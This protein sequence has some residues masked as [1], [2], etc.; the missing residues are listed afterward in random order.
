MSKKF[1]AKS[2]VSLLASMLLVQAALA[3]NEESTADVSSN[4]RAENSLKV[5]VSGADVK[6]DAPKQMLGEVLVTATSETSD[7]QRNN[8]SYAGKTATA[9]GKVPLINRQIPNSVSVLTRKQ[10]DDQNMVTMGD[11]MQQ[12]TGVNVI[13][14]DTLNNQYFARGYG[15]G[16][17]YDGIPSYNGMTPSHQFDLVLYERIEVLRG[18][19]G[20]LRGSGEPGGVVN[21]IKKR[22]KDTFG[23]STLVSA[24]SWSNYR[25]EGDITGAL[26]ADK[27][28]RGRLIV[29]DE[30]RKYFYDHTHS[31]KWLASASLEYDF[32]PQTTVS[33]AFSAQDQDVKAPSSG[34]PAYA[35]LTNPNTGIYPLLN[36]S[37]S[38]FNVPD[39]G[40]T[41]YH[42]EETAVSAEHKFDNQWVTKAAV[43]H[44][45]QH[46][47]YKYAFTSTGVNPNTNLVSYRSFGGNYDYTRD[48]LDIYADGPFVLLGRTHNLLFG[49]NSEVYTSAG[50]SGNGPNYTNVVFGDVSTLIEPAIAYTAGSES[51]TYQQGLYSQL[52]LSVTDPLTAVLG[53]RS[54]TF[55][56]KTR[57]IAPS[58]QTAWANGA[59]ANDVVT[60]FA[61]VL[62]DLNK[63]VTLYSSYADIFVPQTQ[64]KADGS[65]LDPRVGHQYEVGS[66]G[67]FFDGDLLA[68]L[69][70]FNIRDKNRAFADP[71]YPTS[72]FY[73]NAGEIESKGWE[74]ET[75]GKPLARLDVTAGYTHLTTHYLADR[76]NQGLVYSIQTPVHQFK[77]W[78]NYRFSAEGALSGFNL[79]LGLLANS[80]VQSSRG[81][82]NQLMTGGYA[83]VNGNVGYQI[84]KKSSLSLQVNNLLDRKYYASVGTPNTYNFYGEPRSFNLVLRTSY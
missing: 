32:S 30:D 53:G 49:F 10:M 28:M 67:E 16:V 74:V 4:G 2:V 80:A 21:M 41:L 40:K 22:P 47:Y 62:Y 6:G 56:I 5:G 37:R 27:T 50:K 78:S 7:E 44:R 75:T 66:K 8:A 69:A 55:K 73:L 12:V 42:T 31:K 19:S 48:G 58:T 68:S 39:W 18:P 11:A 59:K 36:V 63:Q 81:W 65:T 38:T 83:V 54:T 45:A 23:A 70:L 84:D 64:L 57:N 9:A 82:R 29:A 79:G 34:L 51:R 14:N 35:N 17:M 77:L 52:R 76:T 26:N 43:N 15:M 1:V 3:A 33:L 46:N 13:A 60:P 24:G 72:S 71:A 25:A 20:L 61:G